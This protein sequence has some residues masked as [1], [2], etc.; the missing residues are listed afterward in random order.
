MA[1]AS[2]LFFGR[3]PFSFKEPIVVA[4]TQV[5]ILTP[6]IIG[7]VMEGSIGMQTYTSKTDERNRGENRYSKDD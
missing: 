4:V 1:M 7:K 5:T 2:K 6:S 3:T